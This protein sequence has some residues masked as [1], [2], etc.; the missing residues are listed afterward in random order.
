MASGTDR[1]SRGRE[2][3]R[4]PTSLPTMGCLNLSTKFTA[5]AGSIS[6]AAR[7]APFQVSCYDDCYFM[8]QIRAGESLHLSWTFLGWLNS[9]PH[10]SS[11]TLDLPTQRV[12]KARSLPTI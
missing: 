12:C 1:T 10:V 11:R 4:M 2:R 6:Q 9:P 3:T 7:I 8:S 5:I